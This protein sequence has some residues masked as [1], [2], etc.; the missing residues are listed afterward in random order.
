MTCPQALSFRAS[1]TGLAM[2]NGPQCPVRS[3]S[4]PATGQH[5]IRAGFVQIRLPNSNS[6]GL[7]EWNNVTSLAPRNLRPSPPPQALTSDPNPK[8]F[9]SEK[10]V[11]NRN[12]T[13]NAQHT[14]RPTP[15]MPPPS[16]SSARLPHSEKESLCRMDFCRDLVEFRLPAIV[17]GVI[18]SK[19]GSQANC[20]HQRNE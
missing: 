8:A 13:Y 17:R 19:S 15:K 10:P 14:P 18:G 7:S 2:R 3:G 9:F 1:L 6:F 16:S 20:G 11:R 12:G 4:S 5:S